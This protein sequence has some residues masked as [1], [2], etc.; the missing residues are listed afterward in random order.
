VFDKWV[1]DFVGPINPLVRR[2]GDRYII[3]TTKYLTRWV[4][5]VAVKDCSID[6]AS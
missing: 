6:T 4:E 5:A 2:L 1:V 3:T